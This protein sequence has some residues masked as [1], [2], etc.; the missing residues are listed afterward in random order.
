M[1]RLIAW[2][3]CL[4]LLGCSESG[5]T[6]EEK[7]TVNV[8]NWAGFIDP[9]VIRAFEQDTGIK[10]HY[11]TYDSN[12]QLETLLLTGHTQYD[13]VVPGGAFFERGIQAHLYEPLDA[14][15]F[16]ILATSTHKPP[17]RPRCTT[18]RLA[19][20]HPT[21]GWSPLASPTTPSVSG[22][23]CRGRR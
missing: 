1:M 21:C 22:S 5:H 18:H 4:A 14:G 8:F 2:S 12:E 17:G 9:V 23:A 7:A 10:V 20:V 16:Q 15:T 13:V 3:L 11:S 19:S 6:P